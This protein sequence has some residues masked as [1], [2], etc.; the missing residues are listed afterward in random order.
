[1]SGQKPDGGVLF[2]TCDVC[3]AA[4]G[5]LRVAGKNFTEY[6]CPACT[7]KNA[8]YAGAIGHLTMLY[9]VSLEAWEYIWASEKY[10]IEN[11]AEVSRL[12]GIDLGEKAEAE[13]KEGES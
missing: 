6:N 7:R 10:V 12:T 1:V 4:D 11:V 13:L 5:V 9:G 8:L 3:G 2:G